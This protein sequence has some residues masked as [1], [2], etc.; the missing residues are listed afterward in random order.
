MA[1]GMF[2]V[3]AMTRTTVNCV[4]CNFT[5]VWVEIE[6]K[7]LKVTLL[8]QEGCTFAV[9]D[10][11][12]Q[13]P[14]HRRC[15]PTGSFWDRLP[16]FLKLFLGFS[17]WKIVKIK[18]EGIV[19]WTLGSFIFVYV[20]ICRLLGLLYLPKLGLFQKDNFYFLSSNTILLS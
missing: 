8:H 20:C 9:F 14:F 2:L 12:E 5:H 15:L 1:Y 17:L 6:D 13:I 3:F 18:V 4:H 16:V 11:C 19:W 10:N 7:F